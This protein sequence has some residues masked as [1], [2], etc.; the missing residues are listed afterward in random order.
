MPLR[1]P[2]SS[3]PD[4]I[5]HIFDRSSSTALP[6]EWSHL[7]LQ[8]NASHTQNHLWYIKHLSPAA[9]L[10]RALSNHTSF[11]VLSVAISIP[12]HNLAGQLLLVKAEVRKH[13]EEAIEQKDG[14]DND[15]GSGR[16]AADGQSDAEDR[17]Q[18]EGQHNAPKR[19]RDDKDGAGEPRSSRSWGV[20]KVAEW[21]DNISPSD[22][23]TTVWTLGES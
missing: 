3:A 14:S 18:R 20:R 23:D 4:Q 2:A 17:S 1:A 9:V 7:Q 8:Q 22:E 16:G 6:T 12:L 11:N 15:P 19:K 10:A 21:I 13:A 5:V